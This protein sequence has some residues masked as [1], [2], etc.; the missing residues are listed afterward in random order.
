MGFRTVVVLNNDQAHQWE[1]DPLLGQKIWETSC[2]VN[3]ESKRFEYGQIIEQV[4]ADVQTVALLDGYGGQA[5]AHDHWRGHEDFDTHKLRMLKRFADEL[6]YS[7]R[8]KAKKVV[9]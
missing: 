8:K 4:H 2:R 6:G 3:Q 7:V 5:V 9:I 1:H